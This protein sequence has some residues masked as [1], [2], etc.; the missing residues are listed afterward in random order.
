MIDKKILRQNDCQTDR[1]YFN[2]IL[3]YYFEEKHSQVL[4]LL[5]NLTEHQKEFFWSYANSRFIKREDSVLLFEMMS[6]QYLN[7]SYSSISDN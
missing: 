5:S 3:D 1:E 6:A 2:K 4:M 7:T